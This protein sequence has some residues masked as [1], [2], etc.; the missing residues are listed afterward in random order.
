MGH[1]WLVPLPV[2][3]CL[4]KQGRLEYLWA[5]GGS[6]TFQGSLWGNHSP[7]MPV[8]KHQEAFMK[9]EEIFT[10]ALEFEK[11]IR[12]LYVSAVKTIDHEKGKAFFAKLANDEQSHIDFLEYSLEQLKTNSDLDISRLTATTVPYVA[13]LDTTIE[14]M[15][16]KIPEQMLGDIK[17]VLNSALKLEVETTAFYKK[18]FENAEKGPIK[19]VLEKFYT[20]EQ[21]HVDAVQVELDFS[22]DNGHWFDFMEKDMEEG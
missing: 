5:T 13:E 21:K 1:G 4:D 16:T 9:S 2:D 8:I 10:R 3:I 11:K 22:S 12:D 19:E 15:K 14:K 17:R 6:L 20:I 7:K 18:A